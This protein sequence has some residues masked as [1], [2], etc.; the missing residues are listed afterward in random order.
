M[1]NT[2]QVLWR[3]GRL[4]VSKKQGP[5]RIET[6]PKSISTSVSEERNAQSR[7]VC[8][9]AVSPTATV[10]CLETHPFKPG[11]RCPTT[12]LEKSIPL[13]IFPIL[14]YSTNFAE[15]V[16]RPNRKNDA[17]HTNLAVSN[18]VPPS[19]RNVYSLSTATSKEHKLKNLREEVHPLIGNRA[20]RLAVWTISGEDYLRREFQKQLS[21]LSQVQDKK[22]QSQITIYPGECELAGVINKRLIHFHVM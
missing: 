2:F 9:K 12:Y 1:Q 13:C 18:L 17:C 8:I 14:P 7:F 21:N 5:I 20:L 11:D 4:A 15:S 6:F 3:W 16:L 10:F 22:F 19:T